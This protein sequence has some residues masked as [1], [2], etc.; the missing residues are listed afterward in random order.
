MAERS[1]SG[2]E[3]SGVESW[4]PFYIRAKYALADFARLSY[5]ILYVT[6]EDYWQG[7]GFVP[8]GSL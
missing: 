8:A 5:M 6:A 2:V 7:S 1:V 4:L 3:F